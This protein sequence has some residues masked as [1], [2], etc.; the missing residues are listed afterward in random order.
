MSFAFVLC[1]L[2][3]FHA[4]S[5]LFK[6]ATLL[7]RIC[8]WMTDHKTRTDPTHAYPSPCQNSWIHSSADLFGHIRLR[9]RMMEGDADLSI[10]ALDGLDGS[11]YVGPLQRDRFIL[12]SAQAL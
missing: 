10:G 8:S 5:I 9:T 7:R 4:I 2:L 6:Q 1:L 12:L 11:A 3:G